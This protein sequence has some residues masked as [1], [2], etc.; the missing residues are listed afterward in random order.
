MKK[1]KNF[2]KICIFARKFIKNIMYQLIKQTHS[3]C[4]YLV[5]AVLI[6]AVINA[7]IGFFGKRKYF[8]IKDLRLSLFALVFS[9]IQLLLGLL[10]YVTTPRL[11]MWSEGARVVMKDSLL[12]QLLV[13]HPMINI[14]AVTLITVGWVKLK[15]Q[16]E[17]RKMYGKIALFYGIALVCLLSMIPWK[18]WWSV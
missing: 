5:L 17:V 14:I 3:L 6:I 7:I 11:Q 1:E 13:E 12:R 18:L 8:G 9:H 16:T 15:K 2:K 4:A 10:V